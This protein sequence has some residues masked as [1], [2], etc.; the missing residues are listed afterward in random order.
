VPLDRRTGTLNKGKL[1]STHT[2]T[3]SHTHH[4]PYCKPLIER[5]VVAMVVNSTGHTVSSILSY[6][7]SIVIAICTAFKSQTRVVSS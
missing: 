1:P 4:S 6:P 2:H 7:F 3:H 5:T